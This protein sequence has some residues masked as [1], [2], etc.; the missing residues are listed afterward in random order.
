ME[1]ADE[2]AFGNV[3]LTQTRMAILTI[4]NT[5]DADLTLDNVS[6]SEGSEMGFAVAGG[7]VEGVVLAPA[8]TLDVSVTFTPAAAGVVTGL[9]QVV[10]NAANEPVLERPLSGTGTA[11]PVAVVTVTP[12]QVNFGNVALG[13]QATA[14]VQIAN[15]GDADL[16]VEEVL[17]AEGSVSGF[18]VTGVPEGPT[19]L[20]PGQVLSVSAVFTPLAS[21]AVTGTLSVLSDAS[22]GPE[23]LVTL[24]ATGLGG[25]EL[26][27][28][29]PS[30][31]FGDAELESPQTAD[32]VIA[33]TGDVSAT[34]T[35]VEIVAG[36]DVGF[37]L[38]NAFAGALVL[39]PS[40]S[41]TVRV[42]YTPLTLGAVGGLIRI[43]SNAG[44]IDVL[45]SGVGVSVP[46][47]VAVSPEELVY[48]EVLLGES[49][50]QVLT[51]NYKVMVCILPC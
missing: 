51:I 34:V 31:D 25:P 17:I 13:T 9:L 32:I 10:S 29:P 43:E 30:L 28:T 47:S 50:E 24:Q 33:N 23:Q 46:V 14:A 19:V 41:T 35:N 6:V 1:P 15:T 37:A 12:A 2:V 16:T 11:I 45:L 7:P 18:S 27:V 48:G 5:G 36:A 49:Q 40:D 21:G 38:Q 26:S 20:A 44:D 39:D 42:V 22:N 3:E 8:D 4:T